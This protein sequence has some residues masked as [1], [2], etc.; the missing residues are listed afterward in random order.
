[1]SLHTLGHPSFKC[2]KPLV[3]C[4]ICK[5]LGHQSSACKRLS[6]NNSEKTQD[7]IVSEIKTVG[8]LDDKYVLPISANGIRK[9]CYVDLEF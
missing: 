1:M 3:S 2:S 4:S 9:K 5:R 8:S 6:R 7:K